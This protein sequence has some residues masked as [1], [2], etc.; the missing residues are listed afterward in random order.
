MKP[1]ILTDFGAMVVSVIAAAFI[2]AVLAL[3]IAGWIG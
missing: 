1:P 2:V 3:A